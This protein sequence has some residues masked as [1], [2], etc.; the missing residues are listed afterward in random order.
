MSEEVQALVEALQ[1]GS[2]AAQ[3]EA[4]EKLARM[5]SAAQAAAVPLVEA[6]AC[7]DEALRDWVVAALEG[8]GPPPAAHVGR[9]AALVGHES[10]DTA[11]WAATLLGRLGERAEGALPALVEGLA[12]HVE[13]PV[14]ERA[15]WALGQ[16]GPRAGA[17][18]EALERAA[19]SADRR[20]ARLAQEALGR[21]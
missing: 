1:T 21:L 20:L 11:Y 12:Q 19:E 16:I 10:L 17:A 2:A 9:L 14:R 3:L 15:A 8:L 13:M 7:E 4:A 5:E 18:R 6:C